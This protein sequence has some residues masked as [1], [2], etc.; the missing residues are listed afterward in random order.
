MTPIMKYLMPLIAALLLTAC[1]EGTDAAATLSVTAADLFYESQG[2]DG[3]ILTADARDLTVSTPAAWCHATITDY[4]V[5]LHVDANVSLEGRS[6]ILTLSSGGQHVELTVQQRG[7]IYQFPHEHR[8]I[9]N[10]AAGNGQMPIMY[11]NATQVSTSAPWLTARLDG[12]TLRYAFGQNETRSIRSAWIRVSSGIYS[13]SLQVLQYNMQQDIL[14]RYELHAIGRGN[15]E[16]VLPARLAYTGRTLYLTLTDRSFTIPVTFDESDLSLHITNGVNIGRWRSPDDDVNYFVHLV[17]TS[18]HDSV[19]AVTISPSY[20][21]KAPMD[22]NPQ[23]NTTTGTFGDDGSWARTGYQPNAFLFYLST[24]RDL[25]NSTAAG[26][27]EALNYPWLKKLPG[28][29]TSQTADK[30]NE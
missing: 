22:Y 6:A 30:S 12:D 3:R 16:V 17:V 15:T 4:R 7:I 25:T 29:N 13:D 21:T 23:L 28:A 10:D 9:Y 26:Y 11:D 24:S 19:Y 8:Y 2:G 18:L 20:G 1:D 27:M 14:G 5:D